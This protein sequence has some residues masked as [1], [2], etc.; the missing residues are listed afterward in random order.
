VN[1]LILIR[2]KQAS[3]SILGI[4][5]EVNPVIKPPETTPDPA[6]TQIT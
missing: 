2:N 3:F 1:I 6:S 4:P 5:P